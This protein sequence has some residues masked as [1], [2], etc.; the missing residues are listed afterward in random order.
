M[1]HQQQNPELL[2]PVSNMP[3]LLAAIHSGADAVYF[4]VPTFNARR[5]TV[6]FTIQQLKEM[7]EMS[8]LYGVKVHLAFNVLIFENE[9]EQVIKLLEK[10]IPLN[11]DAFIVQDIGLIRLI[12]SIAPEQIIHGSTQMTVTNHL[13]IKFLDDLNIKRFVL[14]RENSLPEI[15]KIKEH[16]KKE[17]EVFVHGA[18]CVAYSGQCLTSEALGGRSA[19]RGQCAQSC[20][21]EYE[22]FVDGEKKDLKNRPYL[23]S[24]KD[25]C[26]V[27]EIPTLIKAGVDSFKIEGRLKSPEYVAAAASTYKKAI[28]SQFP[29]SPHEIY[30]LK[31]TYSRDF[32]SGWLHGV[33]HQS[34]VDGSFS[35]HR[36][37]QI[38][39]LEKI[40]AKKVWIK[41]LKDQNIEL[42]PGDGILFADKKNESGAALY[43]V[44]SNSDYY[45][46]T[47]SNH[48]S[49]NTLK[50][51][52]PVYQNSSP[53]IEKKWQSLWTTRDKQKKIPLSIFVIAKDQQKLK[54]FVYDD[55]QNKL[56]LESK[57]ILSPA[58][59]SPLTKENILTEFS[60]LGTTCFKLSKLECQIEEN[61][62]LSNQSLK[63]I[64]QEM[65]L[66]L[67][68][69]RVG[70]RPPMIQKYIFNKM[71]DQNLTTDKPRLN[72]LLRSSEQVFGLTKKEQWATI[73]NH[74]ILDFEF[75]QDYLVSLNAL[76]SAKFKVGIATNRILKP[77]E[78]YHLAQLVRLRPDF[79]LV[80][81]LGAIEY[82]TEHAPSLLLKGDFS[83]NIANSL[84][85]NYFLS[86]KVSSICPSYDLNKKQLDELLE[87]IPASKAEIVIHQHMPE[88]HMEHC[89]FAAFL[90]NGKDF[91]DC[92]KPCESHSVHVRDPYGVSHLLKADQECRNTLY[93]SE[94]QSGI[95]FIPEWT[96]LGVREF[97][98]EFLQENAQEMQEKI[99]IYLDL[100]CQNITPEVA[101]ERIATK[102]KFGVTPG[103]LSFG[104]QY[105]DRKR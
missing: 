60:K 2:L 21:Q 13:A 99:E 100:L 11:P 20:R 53:V 12:K 79:I 7:I 102:E 4:G 101:L 43:S 58:I 66:S 35:S 97:R 38:G 28:L 57:D 48:F 42:N 63:N 10:I 87:N 72:I 90:S 83:L 70:R 98:I 32:F 17:I 30:P 36:G 22:M 47:F 67:N 29:L 105:Q 96:N 8:H 39:H 78:M 49:L 73:I 6:D 88:F 52:C 19:N 65:V 44:D 1:H 34:L 3:M 24:P 18:L 62:F 27:A 76:R 61:I 25:L 71:K 46:L 81:N 9:L 56:Q 51:N 84:S 55:A 50:I 93:K 41:K 15:I 5:R 26:G 68:K 89:V 54:V 64:R 104:D 45:I 95:S 74:V 14:G 85:A 103:Q 23:F 40:Q 92:G 77:L 75:G 16:T 59:S 80:R 94:A 31:V 91:K 37:N 82:F 86:K 69:I 33:N